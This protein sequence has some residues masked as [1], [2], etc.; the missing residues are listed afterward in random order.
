[1]SDHTPGPWVVELDPDGGFIITNGPAQ[2]DGTWVLASR[3][4]IAHL[5]GQ[6]RANAW[7][8][9]AAPDLL[10]MARIALRAIEQHDILEGT[11]GR[12]RPVKTLLREVIAKATI[13]SVDEAAYIT[14]HEW[15][16][17]VDE[18]YCLRC[19]YSWRF[20]ADFRLACPARPGSK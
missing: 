19:G 8:M 9:A 12:E 1:M 16:E 6:S 5:A 18:P 20:I 13:S 7:L 17:R 10:E 15:Q 3:G 4:P 11:P 2:R 14:T